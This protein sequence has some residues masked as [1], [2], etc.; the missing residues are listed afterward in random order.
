MPDR[1]DV[2]CGDQRV[3]CRAGPSGARLPCRRAGADGVAVR[4]DVAP[5]PAGHRRSALNAAV[6][7]WAVE[8]LATQQAASAHAAGQVLLPDTAGRRAGG[9]VI[10]ID[11]KTL[12]GLAPRS[13]P[14]HIAAACSGGDRAHIDV[15]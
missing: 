4:G 15:A 6:A 14:D 8:R 13:T 2:V 12:P 10:A 3:D 11:D 7:G 1:R 5:L 9:R